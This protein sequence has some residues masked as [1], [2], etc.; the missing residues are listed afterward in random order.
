MKRVHPSILTHGVTET[1]AETLTVV[2]QQNESEQQPDEKN[3]S[4]RG[5]A[6]DNEIIR[7]SVLQWRTT[8]NNR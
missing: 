6:H 8:K 5:I 3:I 1:L 7:E 2:L 4:L